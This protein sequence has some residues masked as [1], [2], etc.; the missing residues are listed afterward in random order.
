MNIEFAKS[1][2]LH[3]LVLNYSVLLLWFLVFI[4]ARGWLFRL[5]GRWFKMTP[6]QFHAAHYLG[7]SVYKIGELLFNLVPY[8][9]LLCIGRAA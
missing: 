3:C 9:A 1:F 2:L 7:M 8:V 4:S 6:E 5:H